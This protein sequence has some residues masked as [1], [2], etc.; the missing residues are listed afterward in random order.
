M[1]DDMTTP[2]DTCPSN[3]KVWCVKCNRNH[4]RGSLAWQKCNGYSQAMTTP[5]DTPPTPE[6]VAVK[7]I[8]GSIPAKHSTGGGVAPA[9]PSGCGPSE[10]RTPGNAEGVEGPRSTATPEPDIE[11]RARSADGDPRAAARSLC[12]CEYCSA[13][14]PRDNPHFVCPEAMRRYAAAAIRAEREREQKQRGKETNLLLKRLSLLRSMCPPE[15]LS[16]YD[17]TEE[18]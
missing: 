6:G 12:G 2:P 7:E 18:E 11:Q 15:V 5:P 10:K 8:A 17:R 9:V 16:K 13:I 4:W 1:S 14:S 3:R